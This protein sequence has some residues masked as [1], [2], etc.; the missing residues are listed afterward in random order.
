[1]EIKLKPLKV[2]IYI[3]TET[4]VEKFTKVETKL[5]NVFINPFEA[6]LVLT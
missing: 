1:M 4:E 2:K 5:N 3:E 6:E